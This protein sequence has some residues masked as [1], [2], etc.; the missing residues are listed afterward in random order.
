MFNAKMFYQKYNH[1]VMESYH[2]TLAE[3]RGIVEETCGCTKCKGKE[4]FARFFHHTGQWI[5]ELCALEDKLNDEY[6]NTHTLEELLEENHRLY[7][8]L[9]PGRY[10]QS[11]ANP[12]FA[13]QVFGKDVGQ[14]MSSFYC[15]YREY[16]GYAFKRKIFRME[17][18][19]RL[20]IA[21]FR[22]IQAGATDK[23]SLQAPITAFDS[24][25]MERDAEIRFR[26]YYNKEWLFYSSI[27]ME[28]DLS[29]LRYLFRAGEYISDHEIRMAQFLNRYPDDKLHT[30][31]EVIVNAFIMGFQREGKELKNRSAVRVIHNMGQERLLRQVT[32]DFAA[33]GLHAFVCMVQTTDFNKQYAYDHRFDN[34]LVIDAAYM[35]QKEQA[36]GAAAARVKDILEEYCG[37]LLVEKFG[38]APF[39]PQNK[40]EC[41]KLSEEQSALFKAYK[42]AM[43]NINNSY[44]PEKETSF[45]IIAFPT[46][47]I[48]ERF[49][50]IFDDTCKINMLDNDLYEKIQKSIIDA[51]DQGEFVHVKGRGGNRTDIRVRLHKLENPARQ[52]NFVNCVADVNVPLGEV[53][54]SPVLKDTNGLLHLEEVFLDGLKYK[55]L[56]L[57]F[58]DG[59]IT[60][61]TCKNFDDEEDNRKYVQENLLFPNTTLPLGEFAIGTNT[62]AYVVAQKYDIVDILPI[63]IVEKMGPHFAVGDTCFMWAEDLPVHNMIDGKEV[64]ARDNEKSI[65]RKVD[66]QQAYTG[67][68]TD[69]TL[70][71]DGL[72]SISV[73]TY[74]GETV[75][76]LREGRF[77]LPGTEELNKPF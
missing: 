62:Y 68:H 20:F 5:L 1:F 41:L 63:L 6:F 64:I 46:P 15:K 57:Q 7:S 70:P 38:E 17:E 67:C 55:D 11:Y 72:E 34:A 71:Y 53:F 9:M 60:Q 36:Y 58:T 54:T 37:V 66:V 4:A 45:C 77:V 33:R 75:D 59:Y 43:R 29:D 2:Q 22:Q 61:Y 49:E 16:V 18:L 44:M 26:E 24:R 31:S 39:A 74:T 12:A 14:V 76:L 13:V 35:K 56:E 69:I 48:G 30:L 21:V 47:E 40:N 28:Q 42:T 25:E 8:E 50:E 10:E 32:Q 27:A 52:T 73:V 23:E 51:L 65:L 19:N 3:I